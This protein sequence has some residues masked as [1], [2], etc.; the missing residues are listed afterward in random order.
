MIEEG[1]SV[2]ASL[3]PFRRRLSLLGETQNLS[4]HLTGQ[5]RPKCD[6]FGQVGRS[7]SAYGSAQPTVLRLF[8]QER[9]AVRTYGNRFES[10]IVQFIS[11]YLPAICSDSV[12]IPFVRIST[13]IPSEI[14]FVLRVLPK[15]QAA[16]RGG[17][18]FAPK[19]ESQCG[20][21]R[22]SGGLLNH[23]VAASRFRE[24]EAPAD[25]LPTAT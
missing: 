5:P 10:C 15:I 1:A 20:R 18:F 7:G 22:E 19:Y 3:G 11:P 6:Q 8:A 4:L 24:G 12:V 13:E 14:P 23:P 17:F 21:W 2:S 25:P 16:H 9:S